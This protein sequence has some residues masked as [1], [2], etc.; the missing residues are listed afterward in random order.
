VAASFSAPKLFTVAKDLRAMEVYANVDEADIGKLKTGMKSTFTVDAFQSEKFNGTVR[1][2]RKASVMD[3]GV[4]K[5]LVIISAPNPDLKLMPGMTAN[6]IIT[7]ET[8]DDCLRLPNGAIRF[9]P[10]SVTNFPYPAGYNDK[11]GSRT[12]GRKTAA[13]DSNDRYSTLWV[14]GSDNTVRPEKVVAGITDGLYTE[15]K[16]G[17]L[18]EGDMVITG[19]DSGKQKAAAAGTMGGSSGIPGMQRMG[20]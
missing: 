12:A 2:I 19:A 6:V 16:K 13:G 5:Y 11:K 7:S 8:S 4:V 18:K 10:G 17:S 14:A 15:M 20:R 1:Q 9:S 3:Q